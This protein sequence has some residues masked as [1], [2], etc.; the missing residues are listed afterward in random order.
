M[1]SGTG[2][3]QTGSGIEAGTGLGQTGTGTESRAASGGIGGYG[4]PVL[5]G[6][7]PTLDP[8]AGTSTRLPT[9]ILP[10]VGGQL[11]APYGAELTP[12]QTDAL[13]RRLLDVARTIQQP[14]ERA[15]TLERIAR[16][17]IFTSRLNIAHIALD[18]ARRAAAQEPHTMIRDQRTMAVITTLLSLAEAQVREAVAAEESLGVDLAKAIPQ[19]SIKDR[20]ALLL[21]A[22]TEWNRAA[23]LTFVLTN[24]NFRTEMLYRVVDEEARGSESIANQVDKASLGGGD[25]VLARNAGP[26]RAIADRILVS[27]AA[28]ARRDERPGWRDRALIEVVGSAAVSN[29]FARGLE[30]ARTISQPEARSDAMLRLAETQARRGFNAGATRAY[31][32]TAQAIAAIPNRSPRVILAGVLI[33]SLVAVG[34]FEDARSCI[35]LFPDY[36]NQI[37]ALGA[38]VESMGGRGQREQALAWI[39]R[40]GP[41]EYRP[42]LRRRVEEG[43]LDTI[44]RSRGNALSTYSYQ[45]RL[46][47]R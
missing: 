32:E 36:S 27:A 21:Q 25:S 22:E 18:E 39:D 13:Y 9:D 42:Y 28:H 29:Q 35:V 19:R 17:A 46:R 12:E 38:I 23:E 31:A 44:D 15:M 3:G 47:G 33:D 45:G 16:S 37:V 2:L 14:G 34:R 1:E 41:P 43:A 4:L 30:I 5:P 8:G 7:G 20:I 6:T 26:L 24:S 40:E 11:E 10:G